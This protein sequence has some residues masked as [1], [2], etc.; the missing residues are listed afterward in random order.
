MPSTDRLLGETSDLF[1]NLFVQ[2]S[3]ISF[4]NKSLLSKKGFALAFHRSAIIAIIIIRRSPSS[5]SA[6]PA[7]LYVYQPIL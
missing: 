4:I 5:P 1:I 2:I 7:V 6:I 3:F